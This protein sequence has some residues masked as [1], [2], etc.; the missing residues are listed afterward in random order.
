MSS[1]NYDAISKG[2]PDIVVN[3]KS[4]GNGKLRTKGTRN[5]RKGKEFSRGAAHVNF[6]DASFQIGEFCT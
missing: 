3:P 2:F 6:A 1:R 4:R 5:I